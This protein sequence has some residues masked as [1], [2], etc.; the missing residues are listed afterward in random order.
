MAMSL[1]VDSVKT[2]FRASSYFGPEK[3]ERRRERA[4]GDPGDEIEF[5]PLAGSGPAGE[6]P[7]PESAVGP[8]ARQRE[9]I[10]DRAP[11]PGDKLGPVRPDLRPF[12]LDQRIGIGRELIAPEADRRRAHADH[13][14]IALERRGHRIAGNGGGAARQRSGQQQSPQDPPHASPIDANSLTESLVPPVGF[15]S[16]TVH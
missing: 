7:C 1:V 13:L 3:G 14:D 16:R 15:S 11:S 9:E 4:G 12:L 5:G 6:H 10:D 8:A 2:F